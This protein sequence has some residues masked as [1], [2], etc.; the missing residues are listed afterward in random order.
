MTYFPHRGTRGPL[1]FSQLQSNKYI[2]F[3]TIV[4]NKKN[5]N[6][7]CDYNVSFL[8]K[9]ITDVF[10]SSVL[11]WNPGDNDVNRT[12]GKQSEYIQGPLLIVTHANENLKVSKSTFFCFSCLFFSSESDLHHHPH[13]SSDTAVT[14]CDWCLLLQ[15]AGQTVSDPSLKQIINTD[16]RFTL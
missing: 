12:S 2:T 10:P 5:V 9:K 14:D 15:I 8:K 7:C 16:K 11:P 3:D 13:H 4:Q 6:R 1:P